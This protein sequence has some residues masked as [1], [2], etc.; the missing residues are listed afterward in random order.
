MPRRFLALALVTA[1]VLAAAPCAYATLVYVKGTNSAAPT[2]W[3]ARDDGS[4]RHKL[5]TG[6]LPVVSPDGKWAA[7]LDFT[8]NAVRLRR[9]AGTSVRRVATSP[10]IGA[11]AF[12]PDSKTLGMVLHRRLTLYDVASRRS[13]TVAHAYV[14]GF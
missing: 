8:H 1:G 2:V 12:S 7:W 14:N 3:A 13:T 11:I 9:V 10:S 6:S 5:G 4:K